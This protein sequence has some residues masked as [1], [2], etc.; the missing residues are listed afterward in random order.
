MNKA[1]T[2]EKERRILRRIKSHNFFLD[3]IKRGKMTLFE[4]DWGAGAIEWTGG[5]ELIIEILGKEN[6]YLVSIVGGIES[7]DN[8]QAREIQPI[9][10][11]ILPSSRPR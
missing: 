9:V 7:G 5:D 10:N 3:E 1:L 8:I 11:F 6:P 2:P 4:E